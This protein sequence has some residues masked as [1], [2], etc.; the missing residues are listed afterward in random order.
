ML[1]ASLL[2]KAPADVAIQ[3]IEDIKPTLRRSLDARKLTENSVR[4]YM[5]E[6]TLLLKLAKSF[7]WSSSLQVPSAW[8]SVWPQCK[9][10]NCVGLATSLMKLRSEPQ[11]VTEEDLNSWIF[12]YVIGGRSLTTARDRA[13]K[14]R[15]ILARERAVTDGTPSAS[16]AAELTIPN[17]FRSEV[18]RL[19]RWKTGSY[20]SGRAHRGAISEETAKKIG[21]TFCALNRFAQAE[22]NLPAPQSIAEVVNNSLI[23]RYLDWK[24][25]EQGLLGQTLLTRMQGIKGA[26]RHPDYRHLL[27]SWFDDLLEGISIE[28]EDQLAE[29]RA[30]KQVPY[31]TTATIYTKIHAERF[32]STRHGAK[33]LATTIRNELAM[34]WLIILPWRCSNLVGCRIGGDRPNLFKGP[35]SSSSL[36]SVNDWARGALDADPKAE[37]WQCRFSPSETKAKHGVHFLLP[38][39]LIPLLEEYLRH[40]SALLRGQAPETLFVNSLGRKMGVESFEDLVG[41]LTIRHIRKLVNPHTFRHIVAYG[42]LKEHP[43]DYL[44]VSKLL[45][46]RKLE[47]TIRIYASRFNE[48]DGACGMERWFES[49]QNA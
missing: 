3:D 45:F 29:K 2:N 4:T 27:G 1:V 31:E 48:S 37:F 32:S 10:R 23:D 6:I 16:K 26:L 20:S 34:K 5:Y 49:R 42:W 33:A 43:G 21:H 11:F 7:G 44:T 38:R 46:H 19:M 36:I 35:L 47:T 9:E 28:S 25:N 8:E 17:S 24:I 14:F 40:R 12:Q 18:E 41:E 13:E 15:A 22:L 30:A 39:P